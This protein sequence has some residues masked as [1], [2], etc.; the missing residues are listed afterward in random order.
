MEKTPEK[1]SLTIS[2]QNLM[3]PE[4]SALDFNISYV[5]F[6]HTTPLKIYS[7]SF[8]K[9][10]HSKKPYKMFNSLSG[11]STGF[12]Q[13]KTLICMQCHRA[14]FGGHVELAR[15]LIEHGADESAQTKDG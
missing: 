8:F 4:E 5:V 6:F 7:N 10:C 3:S 2:V 11:F 12:L 1:E 9:V 14:S 13:L 15:L